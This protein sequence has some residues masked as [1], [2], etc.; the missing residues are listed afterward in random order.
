[1][2]TGNP[3]IAETDKSDC[4]NVIRNCEQFVETVTPVS[5]KSKEEENNLSDLCSTNKKKSPF[6][7]KKEINFQTKSLPSPVN[8]EN[9]KATKG[10][11]PSW[12]RKSEDDAV[13]PPAKKFAPVITPQTKKFSSSLLSTG[14][15][16][17]NISSPYTVKQANF[18]GLN[19]GSVSSRENEIQ[20][21]Q[22][23]KLRKTDDVMNGS[24]SMIL[25][26][27]Q[28]VLTSKQLTTSSITG[29]GVSAD[30]A[31]VQPPLAAVNSRT[32]V[33]ETGSARA[34]NGGWKAGVASSKSPAHQYVG[35]RRKQTIDISGKFVWL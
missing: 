27:N 5:L 1:M 32:P 23:F 9:I 15:E 7:E 8:S 2:F 4:E 30:S 21:Q 35:M 34:V 13:T 19:N 33:C 18:H 25:P 10:R 11:T 14:Q 3:S 28:T 22:Q 20:S 12:K 17:N 31:H 6:V 24:P 26:G 29:A 16:Q